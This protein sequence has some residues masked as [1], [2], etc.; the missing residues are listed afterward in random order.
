M[1][2]Q[3]YIL[4]IFILAT[5]LV[6]KIALGQ[7]ESSIEI[8]SAFKKGEV[9]KYQ[10]VNTSKSFVREGYYEVFNSSLK[11]VIV[12][13]I[14]TRPDQTLIEWTFDRVVFVDST[15]QNDPFLYLMNTL[16]KKMTVR[17]IVNSQ[18]IIQSISNLEE[19]KTKT[20]QQIDGIIQQMSQNNSIDASLVETYK[21]QLEMT[22]SS[23]ELFDA[24]VLEDVYRFHE[25][26]G[27][28]F[29]KDRKNHIQEKG[30]PA[31][32]YDVKLASCNNNS[33]Q[34]NG[35]LVSAF[36]DKKG[37]KIYQFELPGFWLQTYS[38]KWYAT[39]PMN[40]S[41]SYTINLTSSQ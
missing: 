15:D 40:V 34:L 30:T 20:L 5:L 21:F 9:K 14:D 26:Y 16:N 33:C 2:L 32:G 29:Q 24:L 38:S 36:S 28:S 22:L 37:K 3:Q 18:G 1:R 25:L 4:L 12:K 17:Y 41:N 19:I 7:D 27:Q 8:T 35:D 10:I 31:D 39:L 23:Q 11:D 6:N 13:V